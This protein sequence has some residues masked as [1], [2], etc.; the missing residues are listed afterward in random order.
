MQKNKTN[1]KAN[2]KIKDIITGSKI[3][4]WNKNEVIIINAPTGS[5]KSY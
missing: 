5:G 4:S 3:R 2:K 1:K